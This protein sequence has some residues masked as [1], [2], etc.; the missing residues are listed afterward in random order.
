MLVIVGGSLVIAG[1]ATTTLL[2]ARL[3]RLPCPPLGL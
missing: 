3:K 1:G 2:E